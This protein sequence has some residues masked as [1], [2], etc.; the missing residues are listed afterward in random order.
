MTS[1]DRFSSG[2]HCQFECDPDGKLTTIEFRTSV[3]L[4]QRYIYPCKKTNFIYA[5]EKTVG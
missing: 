1:T 3:M 5:T 2:I 4:T